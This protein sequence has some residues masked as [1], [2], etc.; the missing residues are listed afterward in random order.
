MNVFTAP[1]PGFQPKTEAAGVFIEA[2]GKILY[3]TRAPSRPGP[4]IWG[5]PAGKIESGEDP[6]TAA[7]REVFEEAGIA[8]DDPIPI[9]SLYIRFSHLDDYVFHMFRASLPRQ[10]KLKLSDEHT[11]ARWISPLEAFSLPLIHGGP[12]TLSYYLQ[13]VPFRAPP[14]HIIGLPLRT[15]NT[16]AHIEIPRHWEKFQSQNI[17]LQI[18]S[19]KSSD[20]YAVYTDYVSDHTQPY[21][22]IIGCDTDP[23]ALPPPGMIS[24]RIPSSLYARIPTKGPHDIYPAWQRVWQSDIPRAFT[25]DFELYDSQSISLFIAVKDPS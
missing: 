13:K 15:D 11:E 8:L 2:E 14:L 7:I 19:K 10:P 17:S 24:K 1:P 23:A 18:P 21:T 16:K 20:L 6:R 22:L 4:N 3:L 9:G 5:V 25:A 12:E